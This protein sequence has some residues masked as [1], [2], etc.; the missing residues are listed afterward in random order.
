MLFKIKIIILQLE[1]KTFDMAYTI[2][3]K[4]DWIMIFIYEFGRKH[5]LTMKQA[6]NYLHRFQGM[7][8]LDKHYDYVHT[9]SF[10]SMVD[11]ITDYCH[12]KGGGLQ[13]SY[14]MEQMSIFEMKADMVKKLAI[15]LMSQNKEMN[16]NDALSVVFNSD[17]YQKIM[18]E[19]AGL[20]Y[21]S[22]R[23]VFS[24]LDSEI[25]NGKIC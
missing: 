20:Y 9:Q 12:K 21:Q 10:K 16:M 3:D 25:K 14:I 18:D 6:F 4:L 17:T 15:M 11:D 1:T 22:A 2:S 7:S 19:K 13:W 8:F 5:G 23:Y 24:F